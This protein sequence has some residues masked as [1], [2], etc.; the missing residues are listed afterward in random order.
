MRGARFARPLSLV[1]V[2]RA[3]AVLPDAAVAAQLAVR[4]ALVTL[5]ILTKPVGAPVP[6]SLPIHGRDVI[7]TFCTRLSGAGRAA[8][9]LR[10]LR[11]D[12]LFP[13]GML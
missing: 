6:V 5:P 9:D 10:R 13:A 11:R 8:L 4:L 1:A 3:L 7:R 2:V 12:D